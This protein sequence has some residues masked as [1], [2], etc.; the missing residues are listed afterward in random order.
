MAAPKL[1]PYIGK[2][3]RD[4]PED[5]RSGGRWEQQPTSF[6]DKFFTKGDEALLV[7]GAN[8]TILRVYE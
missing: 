3:F 8:G 6:T 1:S 4:L 5:V 7:V 2:N